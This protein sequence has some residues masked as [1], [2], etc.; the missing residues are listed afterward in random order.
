MLVWSQQALSPH[1]PLY[2]CR[3]SHQLVQQ[4]ARLGMSRPCSIC[5]VAMHAVSHTGMADVNFWDG[6][7]SNVPIEV[8]G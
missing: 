1:Y 5:S 8:I 4:V 3:I 7:K 6:V 2:G